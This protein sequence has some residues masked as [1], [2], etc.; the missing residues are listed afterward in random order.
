[1]IFINRNTR[2]NQTGVKANPD[3]LPILLSDELLRVVISGLRRKHGKFVINFQAFEQEKFC[4]EMTEHS[5]ATD[6]YKF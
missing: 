3:N 2:A 6:L 4:S 5:H 1:M